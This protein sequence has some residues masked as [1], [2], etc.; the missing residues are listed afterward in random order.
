M[1]VSVARAMQCGAMVKAAMVGLASS[2][3]P[4]VFTSRAETVKT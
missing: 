4:R 3:R 2:L 1:A